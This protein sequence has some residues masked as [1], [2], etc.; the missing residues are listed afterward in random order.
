[1]AS[2]EENFLFTTRQVKKLKKGLGEG[3]FRAPQG[4]TLCPY[5]L[6]IEARWKGQRASDESGEVEVR[7]LC[8]QCQRRA[9]FSLSK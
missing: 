1:M 6:H 5:C 4:S 9:T 3:P 7:V 2:R 8:S